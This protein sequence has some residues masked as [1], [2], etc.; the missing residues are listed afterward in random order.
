MLVDVVEKAQHGNPLVSFKEVDTTSSGIAI[1]VAV[2]RIG[3]TEG[4][5]F[6]VRAQNDVDGLGIASVVKS[7]ESALVRAL[8]QD[9]YS[10]NSICWQVA[11]RNIR[12]ATKKFTAIY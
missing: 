10:I 12:V 4:A 3:S 11:E 2:A 6:L 7:G 1:V 8:V 9:F 5:I